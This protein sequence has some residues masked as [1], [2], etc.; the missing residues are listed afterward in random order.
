M[1]EI[2]AAPNVKDTKCTFRLDDP[3]LG[4]EVDCHF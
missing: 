1:V 2:D 4:F 3:L